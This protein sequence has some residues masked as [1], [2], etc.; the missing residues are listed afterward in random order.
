MNRKTTSGS[1]HRAS[2]PPTRRAT[3]TAEVPAV[4]PAPA[5]GRILQFVRDAQTAQLAIMEAYANALKEAF[6]ASTGGRDLPTLLAAQG[7]VFGTAFAE[8]VRRQGELFESWSALQSDLAREWSMPQPALPPGSSTGSAE[9]EPV[10]P[11]ATLDAIQ[12]A[13]ENAANQWTH[14]WQA[15]VPAAVAPP[16]R[17]S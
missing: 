3:P 16:D 10:D 15:A 4:D 7:R 11:K 1:G 13:F 9:A 14:W 5:V 6:E 17:S 2:N 8:A 12:K